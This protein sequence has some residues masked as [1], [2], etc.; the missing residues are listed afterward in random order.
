MVAGD[1][2]EVARELSEFADAGARHFQIRF[3][4]YPNT[5]GC[6]RFVREVMPRLID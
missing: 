2:E 4:D 3:M 5:A 1:T 6:E